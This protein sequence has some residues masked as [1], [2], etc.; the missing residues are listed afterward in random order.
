MKKCLSSLFAAVAALAVAAVL[1]TSGL[2]RYWEWTLSDWRA[3]VMA[4]P[5]PA[6]H[7]PSSRLSMSAKRFSWFSMLASLP[8]SQS[9]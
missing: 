1:Q 9:F 5:A 2:A 4:K 7:P 6:I 8:L 3:R